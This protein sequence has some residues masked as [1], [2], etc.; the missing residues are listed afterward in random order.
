MDELLKSLTEIDKE[1]DEYILVYKPG[2]LE[3]I[4]NKAALELR[5]ALIQ[6]I[7]NKSNED[8]KLG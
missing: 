4:K 7:M 3:L 8:L 5:L 1:L 2:L 6:Q